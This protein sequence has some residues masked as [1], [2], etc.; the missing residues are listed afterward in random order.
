LIPQESVRGTYVQPCANPY[1]PK[2]Q[3]D[4]VFA[5]HRWSSSDPSFPCDRL[6]A[7]NGDGERNGTACERF[8]T[9]PQAFDK[10]GFRSLRD[11]LGSLIDSGLSPRNIPFSGS[12]TAARPSSPGSGSHA[13]SLV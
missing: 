7:Y 10:D 13:M 9:P 6:D 8:G 2:T 1:A 5:E 4:G 11:W 3:A 12:W